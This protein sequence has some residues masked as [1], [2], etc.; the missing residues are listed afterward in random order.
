MPT[1]KIWNILPK[2]ETENRAWIWLS[3]LNQETYEFYEKSVLGF[4]TS[5]EF[6]RFSE[7][8][9]GNIYGILAWNGLEGL[10]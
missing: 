1:S 8:F 7:V 5:R 10:K 3:I 4:K 6:Q 2:S 9:R